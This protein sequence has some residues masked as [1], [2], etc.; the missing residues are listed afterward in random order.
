MTRLEKEALSLELW[1]KNE[2]GV[3][4]SKLTVEESL[5]V[6]REVS[7]VI[8]VDDHTP[9]GRKRNQ[10][11]MSWSTVEKEISKKAR[12]SKSS[13]EK[14]LK[15][16]ANCTSTEGIVNSNQ[17]QGLVPPHHGKPTNFEELNSIIHWACGYFTGDEIPPE[18]ER[19]RVSLLKSM[20]KRP[21]GPCKRGVIVL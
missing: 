6:Y 4:K 16:S 9:Q 8:A 18:T 17:I 1:P 21:L 3:F 20:R 11:I 13:Q 15:G 12:I 19:D 10:T 5:N 14:H 2:N 7:S